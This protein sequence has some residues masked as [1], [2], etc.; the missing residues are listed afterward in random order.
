MAGVAALFAKIGAM[1]F[2]KVDQIDINVLF[3]LSDKAGPNSTEYIDRLTIPFD[4]IENYRPRSVSPL[5]DPLPVRF[6]NGY[7]IKCYRLD[8]PDHITVPVSTE[9]ASVNFR[10]AFDH[11]FVTYSLRLLVML[12]IWKLISG[13]RFTKLRQRLL[14]SPGNGGDHQIVI[15]YHGTD[16]NQ[17]KKQV[18]KTITDPLGQTHLTALGAVF[19]A[20]HVLEQTKSNGLSPRIYYPEDVFQFIPHPST[21]LQF[22]QEHGVV[23]SEK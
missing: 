15:H 9:A 2:E 1:S 10:I 16:K 23:I 14:Y 11:K 12:G 5:T 3:S 22:F 8:T 4:I 21:V 18:Q 7:K 17:R 20:E 13:E 6:P 19:Q